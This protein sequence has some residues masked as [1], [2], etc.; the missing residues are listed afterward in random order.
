MSRIVNIDSDI[1]VNDAE[2]IHYKA[3]TIMMLSVTQHV[4]DVKKIF[5]KF[6]CNN[7]I[8]D[9]WEELQGIHLDDLIIYLESKGFLLNEKHKHKANYE[10]ENFK[11]RGNRYILHFNRQSESNLI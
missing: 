3:D 7:I 10:V 2:S 11:Q 9:S 5:E 1:S 6:E 8:L 4:P